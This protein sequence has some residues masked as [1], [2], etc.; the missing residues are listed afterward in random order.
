MA[1]GTPSAPITSSRG[2]ADTTAGLIYFYTPSAQVRIPLTGPHLPSPLL[3]TLYYLG[4]NYKGASAD[5]R[6]RKKLSIGGKIMRRLNNY[7]G[8]PRVEEKLEKKNP[9]TVA[10]CRKDNYPYLHTLSRTKPYLDTLRK[11]PNLAENQILVGSQSESIAKK[12]LKPRQP[13][14]IEYHSAEKNPNALG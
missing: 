6:R 2:A 4:E 14:R 12:T 7:S 8:W 11:N 1:S 13:I 3:L 10:Q 5:G 9:K